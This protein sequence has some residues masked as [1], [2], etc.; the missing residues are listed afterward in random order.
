MRALITGVTGQ[1]GAYLAQFLKSKGYEVFGAYRRGSTPN[2][3]RLQYLDTDVHFVPMEMLEYEN[4]RRTIR[5]INPDEIYNLAAQSFVGDSFELPTYTVD[6]NGLGML[7]VLEAVRGTDIRLYQAS[8]SELFGCN[9]PPHNEQSPFRP[10]SPYGCAKLLA[11]SLC[12]NYREAHGVKV[13]CGILF[14]HESPLRGEEFVTQRIARG[15]WGDNLALGNV[16]AK[17]DWGHARDYVEAMWLML[18]HDPDDFVIA[19]GR[20]ETVR[21][22]YDV[23]AKVVREFGCEPAELILDQDRYRPAD[24]DHLRGCADKARE[25]LGWTP[26]TSLEELIA[27]MVGAH[28]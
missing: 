16:E 18:Q 20:S 5:S 6:V 15:I 26:K 2:T 25:V 23:A 24:V 17:R 13:S 21:Y 14:N 22:F 7:R 28:A 10:R 4:I 19:T 12:V 1:D 8:T 11:H 3:M 9:P 27:E